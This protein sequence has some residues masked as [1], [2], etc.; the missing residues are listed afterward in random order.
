MHSF[1]YAAV[2]AA[3]LVGIKLDARRRKY[4]KIQRFI[5]EVLPQ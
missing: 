4:Q 5:D 1:L 3:V 2:F